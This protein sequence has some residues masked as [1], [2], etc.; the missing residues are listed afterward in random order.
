MPSQKIAR[1]SRGRHNF[2]H[3]YRK[4]SPKAEALRS[5]RKEA[6]SLPKPCQNRACGPIPTASKRRGIPLQPKET[7]SPTKPCQNRARW[8]AGE[9]EIFSP[10]GRIGQGYTSR[11]HRVQSPQAGPSP[12][13]P[14]PH[15]VV[16]PF[17]AVVPSLY[18]HCIIIG[19]VRHASS[20]IRQSLRTPPPPNSHSADVLFVC[21]PARVAMTGHEYSRRPGRGGV[22]M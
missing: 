19:K 10:R 12:P 13:H 21:V 3:L 14:H 1:P 17:T 16:P 2:T 8:L 5:S 7:S 11:A 22:C 18:H 20:G 9:E 4:L 6:S 15:S